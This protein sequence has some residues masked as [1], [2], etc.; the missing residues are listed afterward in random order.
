MC[1][2]VADVV[3]NVMQHARKAAIHWELVHGTSAAVLLLSFHRPRAT[4]MRG[5]EPWGGSSFMSFNAKG[6]KRVSATTSSGMSKEGGG[7]PPPTHL[8]VASIL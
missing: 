7:G 6:H 2:F 4:K 3:K 5:N 8:S 1:N